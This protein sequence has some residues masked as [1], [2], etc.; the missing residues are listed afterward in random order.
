MDEN[1]R[2]PEWEPVIASLGLAINRLPDCDERKALI[3]RFREMCYWLHETQCV[4]DDQKQ[5]YVAD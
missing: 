3:Q 4:A 2:I 1:F 5:P